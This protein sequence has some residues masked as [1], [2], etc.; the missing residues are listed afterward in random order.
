MTAS[1]RAVLLTA[2]W[3]L[4]WGELSVANVVSGFAVAAVLLVVFP[5]GHRPGW[6][7]RPIRVVALARLA[8]HVLGQLAVSNAVVAREIL[9][10]GS[11]V[12]T[13]VVACRLSSRAESAM[14]LVANIVALSPGLMTVDVRSD[15]PTIYVHVLHFHSAADTRRRIARLE[16]LVVK[17]VRSA[18]DSQVGATTPGRTA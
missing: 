3:V 11:N 4:L 13:A 14:T 6:V 16:R 2:L 5:M 9:T 7:W 10:R 1:G 12:R 17:A 15:P 8:A 18:D